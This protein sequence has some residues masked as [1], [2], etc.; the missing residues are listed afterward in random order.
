MSGIG[1]DFASTADGL[2]GLSDV[3]GGEGAMAQPTRKLKAISNRQ[4]GFITGFADP[5]EKMVF[6]L[7]GSRYSGGLKG[8]ILSFG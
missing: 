4:D 5:I 8:L 2:A 3:S 1:C 7:A 6:L